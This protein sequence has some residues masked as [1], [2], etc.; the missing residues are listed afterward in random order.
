MATYKFEGLVT[1]RTNYSETDRILTIFT[2]DKGMVSVLA[3]GVRKVDSRKGGHVDLLSHTVVQLA[4][5]KN[6]YILTE[7]ELVDSFEGIKASLEKMGWGY[8]M[9]EFINEFVQEGQGSYSLFRILLMALGHLAEADL[10]SS[11]SL[12]HAFELK[13][14]SELGYAPEIRHCVNCGG[15]LS[16][17]GGNGFS[18]ALGGVVCGKCREGD[19][20]ELSKE[21]L[22]LLRDL[23]VEP[24]KKIGRMRVGKRVEKDCMEDVENALQKYVEFLL[25]RQLESSE[26]LKKIR[27]GDFDP[28]KIAAS[29]D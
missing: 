3:K 24:W 1:K 25:E 11:P 18:P 21:S 26:L 27:A 19:C 12:T 22:E 20:I 23:S 15:A 5:G 7:A 16:W 13:A 28:S 17:G 4:E 6:L 9:A 2:R 10:I 8:Y 29:L 14:L